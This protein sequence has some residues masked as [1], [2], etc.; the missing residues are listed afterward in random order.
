MTLKELFNL[1]KDITVGYF[2]GS[3]TEDDKYRKY[4]NEFLKN[5]YRN[6]N[7][8][9]INA[10]IGGTTSFLGV[11]RCERDILS[12]NPDILFVEFSVNDMAG[13][14]D[15][16]Y[17]IYERTMEGIIRKTL[18]LKPDTIIVILGLTTKSMNAYYDK[19][20]IPPSVK[21]HKKIA[22]YYN[23][24][25]INAGYDLFLHI[26]NTNED[27]KDYL[28]DGC[29]PNDK[30]GKFYADIINSFIFDYDWNISLKELINKN[31]LEN[32]TLLMARDYENSE[33]KLSKCTLYGRLPEYIY[34][35]KPG[36]EITLDFYG[37]SFGI[38]CTTE[39]DSG[40]LEY[41]IDNKPFVKLSTWDKYALSFNRAHNYIFDKNLEKKKH[42]V[43]IRVCEEND[44]LSEGTY[45]RIGA[46][47]GEKEI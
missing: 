43:T 11:H 9:E 3:I 46:F 39:K 10:G 5:T 18:S 24:P 20:D 34:A 33:W 41:S 25:Y 13:V 31:N 4:V 12:K 26:K 40:I 22:V 2:G 21:A 14:D 1:K 47:F 32:A 36:S 7:F 23:V 27:I 19:N 35:Y 44:E 30:G 16:D 28:H 15:G 42:T 38:Y 8:T 17:S 45:I 29:H 37:S 6:N